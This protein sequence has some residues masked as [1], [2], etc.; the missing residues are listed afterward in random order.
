MKLLQIYFFT[1]YTLCGKNYETSSDI[2]LYIIYIMW[3]RML[4]I[5]E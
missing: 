4:G 3:K 5:K 2:F 1:L